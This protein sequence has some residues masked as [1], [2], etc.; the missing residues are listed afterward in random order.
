MK[1]QTFFLIYLIFFLSSLHFENLKLFNK[2]IVNNLE[3][4]QSVKYSS[5]VLI[6]YFLPV[7]TISRGIVGRKLLIQSILI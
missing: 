7:S 3:T 2:L 1:I 5:E 4:V 6:F